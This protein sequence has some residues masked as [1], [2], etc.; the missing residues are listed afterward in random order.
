MT[1]HD[2]FQWMAIYSILFLIGT[3]KAKNEGLV[4]VMLAVIVT[5]LL[6]LGR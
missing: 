3:G 2:L 4:R 5:V 1:S 6:M